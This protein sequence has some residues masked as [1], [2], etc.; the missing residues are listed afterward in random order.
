MFG[1]YIVKI[2]AAPIPEIP[3]PITATSIII[4]FVLT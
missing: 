1:H 3:A 4:F 2:E